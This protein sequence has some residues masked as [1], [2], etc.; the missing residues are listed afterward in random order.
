MHI[1]QH[2]N[3]KITSTPGFVTSKVHIELVCKRPIHKVWHYLNRIDTFTK[4][5]IP[6]YRVEFLPKKGETTPSFSV[7]TYNNHHG[8]F[9]NLPAVITNIQ[10]PMHREMQYLYGS[11]VGSF[12]L[13]RPTSL[14]LT[15][16]KV[17]RDHTLVILEINSHIRPWLKN[18][19]ERCN[20][21]L[22]KK[23]LFP[24]LLRQ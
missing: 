11:Y 3:T 20:A 5:Q 18:I 24:S 21:I 1:E 15:F 12:Y 19:W 23:L 9:L 17:D 10:Q 14:L 16:V 22:W 13:V 6:P 8:P 4:G 7:G 2:V